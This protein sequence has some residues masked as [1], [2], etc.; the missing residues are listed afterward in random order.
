M[1]E[2][3]CTLTGVISGIALVAAL[4]Q[5]RGDRSRFESPEQPSIDEAE[6]LKGLTTQLQLLTHRVAADV[7]AHTQRVVH[8]NKRLIPVQNEPERILSAISDLIQAN[9]SMQGQLA[10]AQQRLSKQSEQIEATARQAR[11]DAL[12]GLANRRALEESLKNCIES[13]ESTET[14]DTANPPSPTVV[15]GLLLMDIDFF[16]SFN[17]SY[18]HTTGD[19]VLASFARSISKW[20]DGKFYSAR[21]GGEEFAIILTGKSTTQM[22]QLAAAARAFISEQIITYEDLRLTI[23]ASAGLTIIQPGDSLKRVYERADEGLYR[24]KKSGRN[25]GH[26]LDAGEWRPFP[27]ATPNSDS[28]RISQAEVAAIEATKIITRKHIEEIK[29]HI[30]TPKLNTPHRSETPSIDDSDILDLGSFVERLENQLK[31]LSRA[32]MAATAIMIEAVG[33]APDSVRDFDRSWNDVLDVVQTK[34][35]GIDIICR[36]RQNTLCV[37]M[38]GCSLNAALERAGGMQHLLEERR[39]SS[40]LNHYPE[41]FAMAAATARFNEEAGS[42][43]QRLE[44]ALEEAQDASA[45]E[46]VVSSDNS[47]YF[48]AT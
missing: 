9:E 39:E 17:D 44:D 18:G 12:T 41:R 33:L 32:D 40:V 28:P 2:I 24:S 38:P 14:A 11:T 1:V 3:L 19:A 23:T 34:L 4:M 43:L 22:S 30:A 10:A 8:I 7:S 29:E 13:T 25:C 6:S 45:L 35:R 31:Q 21:Y 42:F 46:L 27:A 36:L 48:H 37:F 16:K 20:C 15:T 5:Q 47:S 26:W